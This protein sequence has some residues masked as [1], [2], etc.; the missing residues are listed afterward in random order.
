MSFPACIVPRSRP[1]C[2]PQ[3]SVLICSGT[4]GPWFFSPLFTH[5]SKKKTREIFHGVVSTL[6]KNNEGDT[7]PFEMVQKCNVLSLYSRTEFRYAKFPTQKKNKKSKEQIIDKH[8]KRIQNT[9]TQ[10]AKVKI[11]N[12]LDFF[13]LRL[14]LLCA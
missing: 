10:L 5:R 8:R 7:T 12:F 2:F 14:E 13:R 3:M 4:R 9:V 11:I 1:T 6:D